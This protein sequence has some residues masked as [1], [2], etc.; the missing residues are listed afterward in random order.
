MVG[1]PR[2]A[3]T[4]Q[5]AGL[6]C[7]PVDHD[8]SG[9]SVDLS[10]RRALVTGAASGIGQACARRLAAAGAT[11]IVADRDGPGAKQVAEELGGEA[12][13]VDL[14]DRASLHPLELDVDVLVN[15]A[16]FQHVAPVTEFPPEIF[17]AMLQVMVEAPFLLA[18]A[19][20]PKMYERGFGR[21]INISSHLGIRATAY[22]AAYV[23]AKHGLIGLSDVLALEGAPHGVT[24]NAICP[25]YART[26]LVENQVAA[27]AKVHGITEEEVEEQIFLS[28]PAIKRF[29]EPTEIAELVAF[30]CTS[31]A[32]FITGAT[33]TLDGGASVR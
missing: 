10:G 8:R 6:R 14:T 17:A 2:G 26:P 11:V 18:R 29:V 30:L 20:L 27:Q 3:G 9:A 5:L 7:T 19:A 31:A 32:S 28:L 22:K 1:N 23:A 16:G 21:V 33:L 12:W 13:V 4:P 15:N 24:S 25:T